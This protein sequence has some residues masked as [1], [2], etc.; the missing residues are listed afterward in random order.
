MHKDLKQ[1]SEVYT[2]IAEDNKLSSFKSFK[3]SR[4]S[5]PLPPPKVIEVSLINFKKA[6]WKY[7][8][9]YVWT[10]EFVRGKAVQRSMQHDDHTHDIHD[11]EQ[12]L[13]N[14]NDE[15]TLDYWAYMYTNEYIVHY[16]F[17]MEEAGGI[18]VILPEIF[19]DN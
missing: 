18:K 5:V 3:D 17:L 7:C 13:E 10:P 14:A 9:D 6:L 19:S 15:N 12:E 8:V 16:K 1:L 2:C 11:A 4:V